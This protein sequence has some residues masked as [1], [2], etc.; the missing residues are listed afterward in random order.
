MSK[1][2]RPRPLSISHEELANR[3]EGVFGKKPPHVPYVYQP[4]PVDNS[5][6]DVYNDE[7]LVSKFDKQQDNK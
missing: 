5:V 3:L 7:R 2:S 6:L 4:E 1:G